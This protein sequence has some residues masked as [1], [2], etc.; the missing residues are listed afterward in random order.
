MTKNCALCGKEFE[1]QTPNRKYCSPECRQKAQVY[2]KICPF[3]DKEFKTRYK[4]QIYCSAQC[5]KK[6]V[7]ADCSATYKKHVSSPSNFDERI[8]QADACGLSYGNYV[9]QLRLGKTFEELKAAYEL[10]QNC[11]W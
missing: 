10:K 8:K 9:A 11:Q 1:T 6:K 4:H 3:C 7:I 5:H 2:Y